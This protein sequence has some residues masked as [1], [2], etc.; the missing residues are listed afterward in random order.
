MGAFASLGAQYLLLPTA[1]CGVVRSWSIFVARLTR[2]LIPLV[3]RG[4]EL[5]SK[6]LHMG[7]DSQVN[8]VLFVSVFPMRIFSLLYSICF[9]EL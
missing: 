6:E 2:L 1:A 4:S 5:S 7:V 9:G 3:V 8:F